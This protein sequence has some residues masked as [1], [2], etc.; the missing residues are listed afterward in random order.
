M[1]DRFDIGECD[2]PEFFRGGL[3]NLHDISVECA[4]RRLYAVSFS[5]K[6]S[7]QNG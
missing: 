3:E 5:T 1:G 6:G 2:G 7:G 4:V